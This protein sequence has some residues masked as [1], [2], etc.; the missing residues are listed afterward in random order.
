MFKG[1]LENQLV[2]VVIGCIFLFMFLKSKSCSTSFISSTTTNGGDPMEACRL[3]CDYLT[4]Q[5]DSKNT[6][7][8]NEC[9]DWVRSHYVKDAGTVHRFY[10]RLRKRLVLQPFYNEP[11]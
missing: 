7:C 10:D 9:Q 8:V 3:Q 5:N 2:W 11:L 6:L 1:K 4:Q